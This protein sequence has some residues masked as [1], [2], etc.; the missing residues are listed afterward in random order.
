M[1]QKI[2]HDVYLGHN[3]RR[4][5]LSRGLTQEQTTARMQIMGCSLSRG[6]YAKIEAGIQNI[7]V[8]ELL[9]LKEILH[10]EFDDFFSPELYS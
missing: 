7:S 8:E 6:T 1:E 2:R 4:L 5:R 10:A 3:I 9:A